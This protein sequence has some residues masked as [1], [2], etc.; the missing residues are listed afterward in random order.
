MA[1]SSFSL[2]GKTGK[3]LGI[4]LVATGVL[5]GGYALLKPSKKEGQKALSGVSRKRKKKGTSKPNGKK[6]KQGKKAKQSKKSKNKGR[7]L[8]K[9]F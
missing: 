9:G 8:L 7:L 4:G 2:S 6:S 3:W 5:L 1:D